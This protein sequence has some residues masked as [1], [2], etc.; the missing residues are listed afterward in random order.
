PNGRLHNSA[1]LDI[2]GVGR[3]ARATVT[4]SFAQSE[5][6]RLLVDVAPLAPEGALRADLL[7]VTGTASLKGVVEPHLIDGLLPGQYTFLRAGRIME[8]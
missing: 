3:V 4:G 2:G 7:T 6:G 1:I 5:Y 8:S